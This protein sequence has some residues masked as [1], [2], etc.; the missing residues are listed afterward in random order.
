MSRTPAVCSPCVYTLLYVGTLYALCLCV[1]GLITPTLLILPHTNP[2]TGQNDSTSHTFAYANTT[3]QWHAH[4]P[5]FRPGSGASPPGP[6]YGTGSVAL[7]KYTIPSGNYTGQ[8]S[9]LFW[10]SLARPLRPLCK[11]YLIFEH[12]WGSLARP[13]EPLCKFYLIFGLFWGSLVRPLGTLCK[14]YLIF[15]HF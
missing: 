14:C 6:I 15:S 1:G 3:A 9:R 12:F 2:H 5:L 11:F 8:I 13:L 7:S 4:A 10:G